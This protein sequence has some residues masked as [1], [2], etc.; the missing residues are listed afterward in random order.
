MIN[1]YILTLSKY[2]D[3]ILIKQKERN[4]SSKSYYKLAYRYKLENKKVDNDKKLLVK[5]LRYRDIYNMSFSVMSKELNI[6]NRR[7]RNLYNTAKQY[8]RLGKLK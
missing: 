7:L 3:N 8:K 1:K 5:I 6:N 4:I 2:Q